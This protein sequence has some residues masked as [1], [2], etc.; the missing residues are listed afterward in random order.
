MWSTAVEH[1]GVDK[2]FALVDKNLELFDICI[3]IVNVSRTLAKY[4]Q[5]NLLNCKHW[6][7]DNSK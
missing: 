4:L 3:S 6:Y 1:E 2:P 5:V 7:S